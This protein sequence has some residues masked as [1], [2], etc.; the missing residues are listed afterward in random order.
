MFLSI[1]Y[2]FK[3]LKPMNTESHHKSLKYLS[4]HAKPENLPL[5][6]KIIRDLRYTSGKKH[7][8]RTGVMHSNLSRYLLQK[9]V[10]HEGN[11]GY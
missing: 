10:E 8:R 11:Q 5:V 1:Y 9:F 3:N 6:M 2:F 4:R 7:V